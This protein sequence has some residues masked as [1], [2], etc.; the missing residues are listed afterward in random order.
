[1][2]WIHRVWLLRG[3]RQRG[4]PPPGGLGLSAHHHEVQRADPLPE[5]AALVLGARETQVV[6]VRQ[7]HPVC[8]DCVSHFRSHWAPRRWSRDRYGANGKRGCPRV[9]AAAD[10]R[11]AVTGTAEARAVINAGWNLHFNL[12]VLL[13]PAFEIGRASCRERV[14]QYV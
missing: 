3:P 7:P 2:E 4:S 8:V 11:F 12:A 13:C 1:M 6:L 5:E 10:T 14:C 9:R